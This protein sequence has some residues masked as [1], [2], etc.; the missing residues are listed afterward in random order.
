MLNTYI[1]VLDVSNLVFDGIELNQK[2]SKLIDG[3]SEMKE[4]SF[5]VTGTPQAGVFRRRPIVDLVQTII[6][7]NLC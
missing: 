3:P 7:T 6:C 1:F 4:K 2:V 5:F